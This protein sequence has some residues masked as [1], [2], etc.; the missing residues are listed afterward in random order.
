MTLPTLSGLP[1]NRL[2]GPTHPVDT[3]KAR[4]GQENEFDIAFKRR[5]HIKAQVLANFIIELASI[6]HRGGGGREWLLSI[7]GA[8]NQSE[9]GASIILE[10][11]NEV[12]VEQSLQF[13][14]KGSNNPVEY[15]ALLAEMKLAR[16]LEVQILIAKSNLKLDR[17]MKLAASFE[18]FTLLHVLRKHNERADLP[19]KL[20][21][22]QRG[23]NNRKGF[24][25]PLLKCLDY[26][27]AE[28]VMREVH[29]GVCG[30]HIRG[31][32]LASKVARADYY[33]PTLR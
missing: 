7:D 16:E 21:S 23:E 29:E 8:S 2:D 18:K 24:S 31:R 12:L 5:G 30:S 32:A 13:E 14:F 3:S 11:P 20:A 26:N 10:G 1:Y 28:Y 19:L 15:E 6:G 25:F 33:W 27:E 17:A 4:L 22:T 9:S